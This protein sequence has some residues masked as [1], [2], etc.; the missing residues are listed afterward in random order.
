VPYFVVMGRE[1]GE[2]MFFFDF[3][4]HVGGMAGPRHLLEFPLQTLACMLPWSL[5]LFAFASRTVWS[6]LGPAKPMAVFL[7]FCV[8]ATFPSCWL[9]DAAVTRYWMPMYPCVAG[10]IG[11]AVQRLAETADISRSRLGFL[12]WRRFGFLPVLSLAVMVA[13]VYS[14]GVVS[15]QQAKSVD[16]VAEVQRLK[17]RLPARANLISL[18]IIHHRFGYFYGTPIEAV[19]WPRKAQDFPTPGSYFCF[20]L[21]A[22]PPTLP[23]A[24]EKVDRVLCDRFYFPVPEGMVVVGRRLPSTPDAESSRPLTTNH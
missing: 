20:D 3:F 18:G 19:P 10:L 23:F 12:V 16:I 24:W 17:S 6:S 21:T 4:Q 14:I 13:L 2:T 7:T 15:F 9:S 5:L 1:A 22:Q 8:L 11:L